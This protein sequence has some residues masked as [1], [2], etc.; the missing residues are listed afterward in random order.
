M[1]ALLAAVATAL[2]ATITTLAWGRWVLLWCATVLVVL[3]VVVVLGSAI[4]PLATL[5]SRASVA[6]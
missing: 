1:S 4:V 6:S 3:V 2:L 5:V